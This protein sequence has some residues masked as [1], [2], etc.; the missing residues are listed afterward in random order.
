MKYIIVAEPTTEPV[1]LAE[2]KLFLRLL[3]DDTSEDDF[4]S[5]LIAAAREYCE[6]FTGRALA[7][8]TIMLY[9]DSIPSEVEVP[10]PP[11]QSVD[12]IEVIDADKA[13][14]E[15]IADT[16]YMIDSG[17]ISSIIFTASAQEVAAHLYPINPVQ[18]TCTVGYDADIPVGIKQAMLL[19]VAHWYEN[20][21]AVATNGEVGERISLGVRSL[22]LQYKIARWC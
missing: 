10:M 13:G 1:T 21:E 17:E 4:I 22:C 6:N 18:I 8:Q 15:L 7:T 20:R 14:H 3:P 5:G 16:D 11:L 9:L 2:V 12:K 19:L